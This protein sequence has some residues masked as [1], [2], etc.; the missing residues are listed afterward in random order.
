MNRCSASSLE[1]VAGLRKVLWVKVTTT[2][3]TDAA[4]RNRNVPRIA[5]VILR[6]RL[7]CSKSSAFSISFLGSFVSGFTGRTESFLRV[8][9]ALRWFVDLLVLFLLSFSEG[10]LPDHIYVILY[11]LSFNKYYFAIHT[12][13]LYSFDDNICAFICHCIYCIKSYK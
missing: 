8:V 9:L 3:R 11:T 1:P 13:F 5:K 10:L 12:D 4:R 6:W 7:A 2:A